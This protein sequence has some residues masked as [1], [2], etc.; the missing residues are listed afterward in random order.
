[1][2]SQIAIVRNMRIRHEKIMVPNACDTLF[3][4][5]ASI[6]RHSFSNQIVITN[7]DSGIA[8]LV[9]CILWL[10]T[11]D[12]SRV[13]VIVATKGDLPHNRYIAH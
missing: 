4:F 10:S 5:G 3:F 11:N 12:G 13:N 2:T 6:D 1:M 9:T 7:D 8:A